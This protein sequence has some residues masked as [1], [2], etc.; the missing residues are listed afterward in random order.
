MPGVIEDR[1]YQGVALAEHVFLQYSV[2]EFP[3]RLDISVEI[4]Q[5]FALAADTGVPGGV[6]RQRKKRILAHVA[7]LWDRTI[8]LCVLYAQ[9]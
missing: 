9:C 7:S 5:L 1:E 8:A 4:M 6:A 2:S 3:G